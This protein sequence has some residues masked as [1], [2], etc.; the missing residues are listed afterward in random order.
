MRVSQ[1]EKNDWARKTRMLAETAKPFGIAFSQTA[2]PAGAR[3]PAPAIVA[4]WWWC[5]W[6]SNKRQ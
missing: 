4:Q 3:A 1:S 5:E 6:R 2:A